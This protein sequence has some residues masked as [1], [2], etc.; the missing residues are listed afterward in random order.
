M[1]ACTQCRL[2][3][4][5]SKCSS[6]K[7]SLC[8][9]VPLKHASRVPG[10]MNCDVVGMHNSIGS[11]PLGLQVDNRICNVDRK[12]RNWKV[13]QWFCATENQLEG[14]GKGVQDC[15]V[16]PAKMYSA[17]TLAAKKAQE[18]LDVAEMRMLRWILCDV[19]KMGRIKND[20]IKGIVKVSEISKKA[21]ERR[22]L[23]WYGHEKG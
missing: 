8:L 19:T 12:A 7:H 23:K 5:S 3:T 2:V 9:D 11:C 10:S 17:Q 6:G 22:L 14:K 20:R 4:S 16:R 13:C 18:K 1:S 21:Q 15:N